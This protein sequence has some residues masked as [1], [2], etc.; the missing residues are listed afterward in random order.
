MPVT[1]AGGGNIGGALSGAVRLRYTSPGDDSG[2]FTQQGMPHKYTPTERRAALLAEKLH[3]P[4]SFFNEAPASV[5]RGWMEVP[6]VF[7]HDM[8]TNTAQ[9]IG[10]ADPVAHAME[11]AFGGERILQNPYADMS[12][13]ALKRNDRG[14]TANPN[15]R[16]MRDALNANM[17]RKPVDEHDFDPWGD[18]HQRW[19]K[20]GWNKILPDDVSTLS[21]AE[22]G[23][24]VVGEILGSLMF[25]SGLASAP[26]RLAQGTIASRFGQ[27]MMKEMEAVGGVVPEITVK[28]I[29]EMGR[30]LDSAKAILDKATR[31]KDQKSISVAMEQIAKV[32]DEAAELLVGSNVARNTAQTIVG[33]TGKL[34]TT[35]DATKAAWTVGGGGA[36]IFSATQIADDDYRSEQEAG[37]LAA[38]AMMGPGM[39]FSGAKSLTS[40]LKRRTKEQ[41]LPSATFTG[42]YDRF[43]TAMKHQGGKPPENAGEDFVDLFRTFDKDGNEVWEVSQEVAEQIKKYAVLKDPD[44]LAAIKTS[45][46]AM[47][48]RASKLLPVVQKTIEKVDDMRGG[49]V[50]AGDQVERVLINGVNSMRNPAKPPPGAEH[51][52]DA[53]AKAVTE[54]GRLFPD[55][56]MPSQ[57][58]EP[59]ASSIQRAAVG[60]EIIGNEAAT[61]KFVQDSYDEAVTAA[62]RNN[63]EIPSPVLSTQT[64]PAWM[65]E[66]KLGSTI[67]PAA[68]ALYA[69]HKK[70]KEAAKQQNTGNVG[71]T[72][73]KGG[74]IYEAD[75]ATAPQPPKPGPK[76]DGA[77]AAAGKMS[78]EE[79]IQY[80]RRLSEIEGSPGAT[81]DMRMFAKEQKEIIQERI[82][83]LGK[84]GER[85]WDKFA[86]ANNAY[87]RHLAMTQGGT[88]RATKRAIEEGGDSAGM[89]P[90]LLDSKGRISPAAVNQIM[91]GRTHPEQPY[92][93]DGIE[94]VRPATPE[95]LGTQ[96]GAEV[97]EFLSSDVGSVAHRIHS[98]LQENRAF[99][100]GLGG[101]ESAFAR[102]VAKQDKSH[103]GTATGA[104]GF[105]EGMAEANRAING[106]V[107]REVKRVIV[108]ELARNGQRFVRDMLNRPRAAAEIMDVLR[109]IP[110][111]EAVLKRQ[112]ALDAVLRG[113]DF[114]NSPAGKLATNILGDKATEIRRWAVHSHKNVEKAVDDV[115]AT[116]GGRADNPQFS[117]S[118]YRTLV[119][120]FGE[121]GASQLAQARFWSMFGEKPDLRRAEAALDSMRGLAKSDS[122]Q[123]RL[124]GQ[125]G[126]RAEEIALQT[127]KS[128]ARD[129]DDLIER[130]SREPRAGDVDV[131]ARVRGGK[132]RPASSLLRRKVADR[133]MNSSQ[134]PEALAQHMDKYADVYEGFLGK[135]T[136]K[137]LQ[138]LTGVSAILRHVDGAVSHGANSSRGAWMRMFQ[139]LGL[140]PGPIMSRIWAIR[141]RIVSVAVATAT[142]APKVLVNQ[143]NR[144]TI[145][146]VA[147]NIFNHAVTGAAM[148]SPERLKKLH[149]A[150]MR[151][152]RSDDDFDEFEKLLRLELKTRPFTRTYGGGYLNENEGKT[153][154]EK[155]FHDV[156]MGR[157]KPEDYQQLHGI[158]G[159]NQ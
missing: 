16:F 98:V 114:W 30:E 116:S 148:D 117:A 88:G 83:G 152:M 62:T 36:G 128:P 19:R 40:M 7:G 103:T 43:Q 46:D 3:P 154:Q 26:F 145:D 37:N 22:R 52:M 93:F 81:A 101:Q 63:I 1:K 51:S 44:F 82:K 67:P 120:H 97:A 158:R 38:L 41:P 90:K 47:N 56:P 130:M 54:A 121:D 2:E 108:N 74:I 142:A 50:D 126:L 136:M 124:L 110:G 112:I 115:F 35:A 49:V 64:A 65:T 96:V 17:A 73:S 8:W 159:F 79:V 75:A 151:T 104:E 149:T 31:A 27:R 76:S 157:M 150:F 144:Q 12:E 147:E 9:Q 71:E 72:K 99:F 95:V 14:D 85:F 140:E 141:Q 89:A 28:R 134:S 13:E 131:F 5:A 70:A 10:D 102:G 6:F 106:A 59:G 58:A 61:A 122:P 55:K 146:Y 113:K 100:A 107:S 105:I 34:A 143:Q 125:L 53:G 20:W 138:A 84:N 139:D 78:G 42:F 94:N 33:G 129:F 45:A 153:T 25:P 29:K 92:G 48:L 18:T 23:G 123:G 21:K 109:G 111:G 118:G 15:A 80:W 87:K 66:A 155:N 86:A 11:N 127:L 135:Q 156:Q 32:Q 60:D 68:K 119:K 4:T 57:G 137:D 133:M 77:R 91:H 69:W 132:E 24:V 39:L